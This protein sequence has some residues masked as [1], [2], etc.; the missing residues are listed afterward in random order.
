QYPQLTTNNIVVVGIR[1]RAWEITL[2]SYYFEPDKPI[3]SYLEQI[4]RVERKMGPKRLIFGGDANAKSTWWG[5]K[6]DDARGDQL[7]GT[8]GELGLHILNEGDVPTFDT[9]RGGK[10]YQSRVDVT[11]CTEDMLDLIDG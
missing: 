11:F 6:E 2:V 5:S 7:M 1:T 9:I 3:E 4:K 10:R 8:L